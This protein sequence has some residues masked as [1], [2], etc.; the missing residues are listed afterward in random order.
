MS[1]STAVIA[2]DVIGCGVIGRRHL[3][4]IADSGRARLVAVAD[5]SEELP[6]RA[7]NEFGANRAYED[8]E[9]LIANPG[10]EAVV[11]A[12]PAE[13][14]YELASIGYDGYLMG[15][16]IHAMMDGE[17]DPDAYLPRELAKLR[18][19]EADL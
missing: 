1:S 11:L 13:P 14:R 8:G 12:L 10:V 17:T 6:D 15:E 16:W 2:C 5:L 4:Q 19:I 7:T 18:S 9:E 3:A